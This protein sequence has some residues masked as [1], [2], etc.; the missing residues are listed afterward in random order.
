M[1]IES[2]VS[3][4][5]VYQDGDRL[6]RVSGFGADGELFPECEGDAKR[7]ADAQYLDAFDLAWRCAL[8]WGGKLVV[9]DWMPESYHSAV[10]T[11]R[12]PFPVK[13]Q[14]PAA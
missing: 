12:Y 2:L 7:F 8:L 10:E 6:W 5:K 3:E 1:S 13:R 14:L 9:P 11:V 4:W